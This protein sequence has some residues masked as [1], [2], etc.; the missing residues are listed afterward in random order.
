MYLKKKNLLEWMCAKISEYNRNEKDADAVCKF[1]E[2]E[3]WRAKIQVLEDMKRLVQSGAFD[4]ELIGIEDYYALQDKHRQALKKIRRL[5]S[6]LTTPSG[7]NL[8]EIL[9]TIKQETQP[10]DGHPDPG[11]LEDCWNEVFEVIAGMEKGAEG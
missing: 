6:M 11:A 10:I 3:R 2:K 7:T 8:R 9:L 4:I 1:D 5:R